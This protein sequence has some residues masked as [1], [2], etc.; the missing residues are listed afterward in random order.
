MLRR[1][2]LSCL[3]KKYEDEFLK[4]LENFDIDE[5]KV[6]TLKNYLTKVFLIENY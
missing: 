2:H 4:I 5:I 3:T 6:D 1:T